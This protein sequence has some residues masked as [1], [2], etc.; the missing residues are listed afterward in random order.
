MINARQAAEAAAAPAPAAA[1]AAAPKAA[2]PAKAAAAPK[3]AKAPAAAPKATST[4]KKKQSQIAAAMSYKDNVVAV[5][6]A[7][8]PVL[9]RIL[10]A[11]NGAA[12]YSSNGDATI[13]ANDLCRMIA[14]ETKHIF[15]SQLRV[16]VVK[17]IMSA[18]QLTILK[19]T[20]DGKKVKTLLATFEGVDKEARQA[21]NPR[22]TAVKINVPAHRVI[23]I[24]PTAATK[25][26][27]KG[28]KN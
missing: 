17:D 25:A 10:D 9:S 8:K 3:A 14:A 21:F 1:A 5:D 15:G 23:K 27:V 7:G 4:R 28:A 18:I 11:K 20:A 22:N 6:E 12:E 13:S 26:Y 2:A 24:K 16:S 19:A